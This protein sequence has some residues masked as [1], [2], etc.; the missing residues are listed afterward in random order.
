MLQKL[1]T[2]LRLYAKISQALRHEMITRCI[3]TANND[4]ENFRC[5]PTFEFGPPTAR[6]SLRF[7]MIYFDHRFA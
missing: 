5:P 1:L 7:L 6:V 2:L 4:I 3:R